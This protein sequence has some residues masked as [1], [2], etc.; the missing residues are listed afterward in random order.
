[1][2]VTLSVRQACAGMNRRIE[3]RVRA[4]SSY[5]ECRGTIIRPSR[6][7]TSSSRARRPTSPQVLIC[8]GRVLPQS[9]RANSDSR[10]TEEQTPLVEPGKSTHCQLCDARPVYGLIFT[11]GRIH[12]SSNSSE[13]ISYDCIPIEARGHL[14]D[15]LASPK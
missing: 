4:S 12:N 14:G 1:M 9:S 8:T 15:C 6:V 5:P 13:I 2:Q 10:Y 11:F 7:P 3:K